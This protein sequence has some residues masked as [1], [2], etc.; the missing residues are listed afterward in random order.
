[1]FK[2][3]CNETFLYTNIVQTLMIDVAHNRTSHFH[4]YFSKAGLTPVNLNNLVMKI[5]F[6]GI[7]SLKILSNVSFLPCMPLRSSY[8]HGI[9]RFYFHLY[10]AFV[11][12]ATAFMLQCIYI[13]EWLNITLCYYRPRSEGD[14]ALGSVRLSVRLFV[15]SRLNRLI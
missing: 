12:K 4:R 8:T 3:P 10:Q 1:M 2:L 11:I 15:L 5:F 7:L 6:K 13:E 9:A 14:N